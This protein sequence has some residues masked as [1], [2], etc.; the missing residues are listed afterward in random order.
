MQGFQR[1][2]SKICI[3]HVGNNSRED[4]S[5]IAESGTNTGFPQKMDQAYTNL[6]TLVQCQLLPN[7]LTSY[8]LEFRLLSCFLQTLPSIFRFSLD[9]VLLQYH[10]T[11]HNNYVLLLDIVLDLDHYCVLW[12]MNHDGGIARPPE[13]LSLFGLDFIAF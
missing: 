6:R 3:Y 9:P 12:T 5:E 4:Q 8:K 7:N 2:S 13:R 10:R 11:Q 1:L